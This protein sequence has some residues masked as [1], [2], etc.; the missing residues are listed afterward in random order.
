M[1]CRLE[2]VVEALDVTLV[3]FSQLDVNLDIS[4]KRESQLSNHL[5]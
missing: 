5:Q 2:R 3:C 1:G 4:G